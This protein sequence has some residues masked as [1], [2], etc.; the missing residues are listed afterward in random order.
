M[1]RPRC[2]AGLILGLALFPACSSSGGG[3][4][5]LNLEPV[6]ISVVFIGA[7][8]TP[9]AGDRL[10][11][12]LSEDVMLT[13]ALLDDNDVTLS[14]GTLGAVASAPTLISSRVVEIVLGNG[15]LFTPGTTTI[16]FGM[17]NDAVED[18]SRIAVTASTPKV[19]TDGDADD[20][21]IDSLTFN[22]IVSL[23]N[24]TGP[25]GGTL[26][27][28]PNG[29]TIDLTYSDGTSAVD[30]TK[31]LIAVNVQTVVGGANHAAGENLLSD[32]TVDTATVAA[33]SYTVP[34][35]V[36]MPNQ[37]IVMTVQ[38]TDTTG[39]ISSPATFT[40]WVVPFSNA[41]RPFETIVNSNQLWFVDFSRDLESYAVNLSNISTPVV[42][43]STANNT[44]DFVDLLSTIGLQHS[45]PINNVIGNKNSN[46]VVFDQ[47]RAEVL[48][49]LSALFPGVN[50]TFTDISPGS[51][52]SPGGFI[53]YNSGSFSQMCIAGSFDTAGSSGVIGL[54][55]FD[56]RNANQDNDCLTDYLGSRLGVFLHTVVNT[57]FKES[58]LSTFRQT[59]D[60]FTP[61]R[62]NRPIGSQ[63]GD[64]M[65]LTGA[66]GGT[67][68]N[69]INLAIQRIARFAAVVAAHEMGHSMGLVQDG[70]MPVGLYANDVVNFPGS[71]AGHIV[72]P[73]S[74]FTGGATN[75][76]S[77]ALSFD[78]TL[79][80]TTRFNT[81]N[82]AYLKERA[83][84]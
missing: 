15:V 55:L 67:R 30:P 8:S 22:S 58:P 54:A 46:E 43:N 50:I 76:M 26:Q 65:R 81:L 6:L 63:A 23:L 10:Q 59:F 39:R 9:S 49:Q 34:A 3:S 7:T 66:L 68:T 51:F 40:F 11:F 60:E 75:V 80:T 24:G 17:G 28:P 19:I 37:T 4:N 38:V 36:V 79:V 35:A 57:G 2:P 82:L 64:G 48:S 69:M 84:Y 21:T 14:S 18:T 74:I 42:V 61:V 31:T 53:D 13:G 29:F 33:A 72:M 41:I 83:L 73:T 16:D 71:N 56:E 47:I 52:P 77:P 70:A 5:A 25:A 12:I 1:T 45:T 44:A 27:V 78:G 62:T 32:L 20:P